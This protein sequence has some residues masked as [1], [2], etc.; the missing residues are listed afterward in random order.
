MGKRAIGYF[1]DPAGTGLPIPVLAEQHR[2]FLDFCAREGY[3]VVATF[4]DGPGARAGRAGYRRLVEVLRRRPRPSDGPAIV[5]ERVEVLGRDMRQAARH[6][7]QLVGLG[8]EVICL[9]DAAQDRVAE[10]ARHWDAAAERARLSERVRAAMRRKAVRGEVLG[11]PPYGYRVGL[12]RRLE[13]VPE[14]AAVVRQIFRLYVQDGLGIRLIAR[15]L[16][17]EGR[18]TRKGGNWSMVTIRDILRN[19]AYLGTYNRFGVRVPGSHPSLVSVEDFHK[20]QE[21]MVARR[22]AGGPRSVSAFLLSGL[23]QCG[24]CGHRMIGVRRR[25]TWKRRTDGGTSTA[26]Y[27]YYQCGSRTNQSVCS[28]HTRR[29]DDLDEEVR[30]ATV[31][32]LLR[33]LAGDAAPAPAVPPPDTPAGIAAR[34]R[35]L[36]RELDEAMDRAAAGALTRAELRA[37][38]IDIAQR[39]LQLE[40]L[41]PSV[42]GDAAAH[43]APPPSA[44]RVAALGRLRADWDHLPFAERRALL[45]DVL[46][47]VIVHD[48]GLEVVLRA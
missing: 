15:R 40:A 25:Q 35:A 29:A 48:D 3:E 41:L 39:Q 32:A 24:A 20:A 33:A 43:L 5:V 30:A 17:E 11:R 10:L 8:V 36:E 27:R 38:S 45:Q 4:A 12:R 42:Q 6:Y 22:T 46:E 44:D 14:E 34:L 26:E 31:E 18:R 28:Y 13:I 16:N 47:R 2:R 21:R 7:F 19:R 1:Y 37:I 23:V 9:A